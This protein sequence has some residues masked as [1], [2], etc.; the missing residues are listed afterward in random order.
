MCINP[1]NLNTEF[2]TGLNSDV[3][4]PASCLVYLLVPKSTDGLLINV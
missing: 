1:C 4:G 3:T 2:I